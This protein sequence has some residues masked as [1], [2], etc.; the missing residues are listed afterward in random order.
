MKKKFSRMQ[1]SIIAVL[2]ALTMIVSPVYGNVAIEGAGKLSLN[3]K[4]TTYTR[5]NQ[6]NKDKK[7]QT[8]QV[9]NLSSKQKV[10]WKSSNTKLATVKAGNKGKAKLTVVLGTTGK[11]KIT[12]TVRNKKGNKKIKVL[13]KNITVVNK[14]SIT[15]KP[16]TPAPPAKT[17]EPTLTPIVTQSPIASSTPQP[18]EEPLDD[19]FWVSTWGS[20]QY[21]IAASDST[22]PKLSKSTFRQVVRTS[23][24]GNELRLTFSN[25][26][27]QTPL[28]IKMVH[29]AKPTENGK[30][31]IDTTT[32]TAV[33]FNNGS[34]SVII[35]AKGKVVSDKID[36][37][38]EALEKIAVSTYFGE[39]PAILTHHAGSRSTSFLQA[40]NTVSNYSMGTST[41]VRWFILS[42]IDIVSSTE[43][44]A[45]VCFG[46][47]ITDGYGTDASYLGQGPDRYTR[48]TD[49]LAGK[50]QAEPKTKNLSVINMGI[51]GNSIFGGQGP[52]AKDRFDR[53]VLNQKGVGYLV[54]IIGVNDIGSAANDDTTLAGRMITEYTTMIN[55]AHAKG[56]RVFAGTITPFYGNAYYSVRREEI[57]QEINT[58]FKQMYEQGKIEGV[59]DFDSHLKDP[60]A[61]PSKILE[62]YNADGLH[63]NVTGYKA[64][65]ELVYDT[66]LAD[67]D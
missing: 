46:D 23:T 61:N 55:K 52:A 63:P 5:T 14:V 53:D 8:I 67:I 66:I 48:W 13:Y 6:T 9:K 38:V 31:L 33:T 10:S 44:R 49:V 20:S 25:E 62:L 21:S 7:T 22:A 41:F 37:P 30:S 50:L 1:R 3:I 32:D 40:G 42:N 59:I 34:E 60:D 35:P 27:G 26:Y 29:I 57:R 12:A 43:N 16:Q 58:W 39:T 65:G 56:I 11:V 51:G 15:P 24:G 28:E 54:F 19:S 47:S 4:T 18:S 2:V 36:Y 45:I 64:M 17:K